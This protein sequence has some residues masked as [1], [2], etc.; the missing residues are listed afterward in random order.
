[1]VKVL[2]F[3][4]FGGGGWTRTNEAVRRLVYSQVE[5]PLSDAATGTALRGRARAPSTP[6]LSHLPLLSL[7]EAPLTL[8]AISRCEPVSGPVSGAD[9]RFYV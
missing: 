5:S 1:M 2:D 4:Q 7:E 3:V 6:V 8:S 9:T